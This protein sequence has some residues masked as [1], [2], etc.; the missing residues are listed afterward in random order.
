M[1][2]IIVLTLLAAA[3]VY[4]SPVHKRGCKYV[5]SLYWCRTPTQRLIC[6]SS[7][8]PG[9]TDCVITTRATDACKETYKSQEGDTC[10]SI[11]G[12]FKLV[13]GTVQG[14]NSF[15]DCPYISPGT[16]VCVSHNW[17]ERT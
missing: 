15:L 17:L 9:F 10:E 1:L 7:P 13:P 5:S 2:G 11:E 16:D 3:G 14:V 6:Y 12:L 4:A 8:S